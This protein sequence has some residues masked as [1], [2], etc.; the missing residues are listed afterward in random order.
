MCRDNNGK[1]DGEPYLQNGVSE[2][3]DGVQI[4]VNQFLGHVY[5]RKQGL[6]GEQAWYLVEAARQQKNKTLVANG[7]VVHE[8]LVTRSNVPVDY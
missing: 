8:R 7:C 6:M 1:R 5:H 3:K 2:R 4:L